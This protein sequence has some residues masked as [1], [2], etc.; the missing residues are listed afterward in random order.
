MSDAKCPYC[1][2]RISFSS[3]PRLGQKVVCPHCGEYLEI[4]E[5]GPV[6]LDFEYDEDD[7]DDEFEDYD[8][9]DEFDAV[10]DFDDFDDDDEDF[11]WDEDD[12]EDF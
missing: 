4:I 1:N 12:E 7:E 10:D 5:L 9:Y 11:D 3:P 2:N 6:V 8:D